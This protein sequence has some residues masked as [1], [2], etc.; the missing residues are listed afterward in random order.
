MQGDVIA[1][2]QNLPSSDILLEIMESSLPALFNLL[3]CT[4]NDVSILEGSVFMLIP[5]AS[6]MLN[7]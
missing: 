3:P 6:V 1:S 4:P 2:W 7:S 5:P